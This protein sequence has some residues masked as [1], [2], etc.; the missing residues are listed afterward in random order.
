MTEFLVR[1]RSE[2]QT[3][4]PGSS[5]EKKLATRIAKKGS[6]GAI[7]AMLGAVFGIPYIWQVVLF[8]VGSIILLVVTRPFAK[9]MLHKDAQPTNSDRI[10]GHLG[11][12]IEEINDMQNTGQI[13]VLGQIWSARTEDGEIVEKGESVRVNAI[14]G[15]KAVVKRAKPED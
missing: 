14:T 9:R 5:P 4:S 2:N 15:V 10:I 7:L 12:V 1:F 3:K 8:V 11:V 13:K 6:F